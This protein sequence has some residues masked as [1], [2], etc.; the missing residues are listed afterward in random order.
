MKW[1]YE[2]DGFKNIKD[3]DYINHKPLW[4]ICNHTYINIKN[5]GNI[6]LLV[7]IGLI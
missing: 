6:K 1:L 2:V 4:F 3:G 7:P 5:Y